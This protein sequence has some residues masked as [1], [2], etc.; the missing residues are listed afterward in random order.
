MANFAGGAASLLANNSSRE[1][2]NN[3]VSHYSESLLIPSEDIMDSIDLAQLTVPEHVVKS[4]S[5]KTLGKPNDARER[6]AVSVHE[7]SVAL[8]QGIDFNSALS[9]VLETIYASMGFNR[10]VTFFRDAGMFRAKVGFGNRMPEALP[11]L[12]FPEACAADV[13]HLSLANKA[14]VFIQDITSSKAASS[15]P[16]W[17]RE[18]L[19]DVDA[20][21]LLPLVFNGRAVGLIYADWRM[22]E[23]GMVEPSELSSMGILRDYFMKALAK[24]K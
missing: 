1:D 4:E 18:A 6:L 21:I 22:G 2:L 14:D 9:M 13:F 24:R 15:I 23:T 11:D 12:I 7:F 8:T 20:F 19:P 10:V 3:F 5:G 17:L 16:I